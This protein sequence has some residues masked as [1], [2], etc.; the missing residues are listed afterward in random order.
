MMNSSA[1]LKRALN[2][3]FLSA[4][5]GQYLF[6][7]APAA[8]LMFVAN[9]MR[10]YYRNDGKVTWII[11]RNVNT[12]NVCVANCKFCNF[13]RIPGHPESYITTIDQYKKKIEVYQVHLQDYD[14]DTCHQITRSPKDLLVRYGRD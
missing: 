4:A 5:E 6:E 14:L 13:Y 12:T 3:E 1:L 11:D 7:H 2:F 8:E 9:E 10:K